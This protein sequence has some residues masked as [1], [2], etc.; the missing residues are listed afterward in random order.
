MSDETETRFSLVIGGPFYRLQ[1]RLGMLGP[2][3]LPTTVAALSLV[4]LAWMPLLALALY[5]NVALNSDLTE[6]SLLLDYSAHARFIIA[7][8]MFVV[9]ERIAEQRL[10]LIIQQFEVSG[11]VDQT[12][13]HQFETVLLH[14]DQRSGS[15]LAEYILLFLAYVASI[16]GVITN[17]SVL[18]TS[19]LGSS[20]DG[21][22]QLTL[23]AW[24]AILVAY[25][26]FWFLLLR[27]LWRFIAWTIL[28]RDIARLNLRLVATHPDQC[29]GIGFL[30]L[31]PPIFATFIFSLSC[32]TAAV[33]FLELSFGGLTLLQMGMLFIV[34][35]ILN[36]IIFV[37][38]LLVFQAPLARL[39]LQTL[40]DY[41]VH[42]TTLSHANESRLI[43][44]KEIELAN[45]Y[46]AVEAMQSVPV[47]KET[48]ISLTVAA[49]LPWLAVVLTQVPLIE[50]IKAV[51]GALM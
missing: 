5:Q 17:I 12:E 18:Q 32:V 39:K 3:L 34:W 1:H 31:F 49:G 21:D 30:G 50:L 8:F 6:R 4:G 28:L 44:G 14:A 46:Q 29:G 38:P 40:L 2:D 26:I 48:F 51:V 10:K 24:W 27:W 23:A 9:M 11:L 47:S 19:W 16:A 43:D 25:P 45:Q 7:I 42:A 20:L 36:M 15:G 41:G 13:H 37:G 35:L 33:V 22:I